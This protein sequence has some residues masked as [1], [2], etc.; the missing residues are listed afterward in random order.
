LP[1]DES[2]AAAQFQQKAGDMPHQRVL[3]FALLRRVAQAQK[4]EQIGVFQRFVRQ[5]RMRRWQAG[6]KIRHRLALPLVQTV[7]DIPLQRGARPALGNG[8]AGIPQTRGDCA[9]SF[10]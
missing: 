8:L 3:D 1:P 9:T 2:E 4:V 5:L 7:A 10:L 6:G